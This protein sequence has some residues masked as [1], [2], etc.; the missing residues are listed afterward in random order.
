MICT[1]E[2]ERCTVAPLSPVAYNYMVPSTS[3]HNY[4]LKLSYPWSSSLWS[5][6]QLA[7]LTPVESR[8]CYGHFIAWWGWIVWCQAQQWAHRHDRTARDIWSQ[9]CSS[10][11]HGSE[12]RFRL[13]LIVGQV[14]T[15]SLVYVFHNVYTNIIIMKNA[16]ALQA[17]L[18]PRQFS[19]FCVLYWCTFG[20]P[21]PAISFLSVQDLRFLFCRYRIMTR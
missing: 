14:M 9:K 16:G 6:W 21:G 18:L 1:K 8:I 7:T 10:R 13:R 19:V 5:A 3:V 17:W 12:M 11:R 2:H 15:P 20:A 4:K